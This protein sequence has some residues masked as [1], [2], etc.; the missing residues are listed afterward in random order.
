MPI[1]DGP[2]ELAE[3]PTPH[4]KGHEIRVKVSVCGICRTDLHIAEGD[5]PL[6]TAPLVLGHEIVGVVDGVG[7]RATKYRQGDRVGISWLGGTCGECKFCL[8]GRENYCPHFRATGWDVNGGFAEYAVVDE[9]VALSV[10]DV[11]LPDEEIAPLMC[12]GIA[13]HCALRLAKVMAGNHVGLY[14]FGPTAYY[15]LKV[16]RHLGLNVYVSSRSEANLERARRHGA[17]WAGNASRR[18]MPTMLDG[19]VVF[20][21]AGAL[22]EAALKQVKVGGVVVLAPVSMSPIRIEDYSNSFWGRDLR[23][24]Y[25]VNVRDAREFLRIA[26]TTDLSMATEVYPL[27]ACQDALIRVKRGEIREPN[28]VIRVA[29]VT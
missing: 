29:E 26:A 20:P 21:P 24:L 14:G 4:P 8:S 27:D 13:G 19:A 15:V 9:N 5:L 10:K 28:A 16:A 1:E 11:E 2:L 22:V 6:E 3:I 17:V 12:P 18:N 23:T 7:E 25:N